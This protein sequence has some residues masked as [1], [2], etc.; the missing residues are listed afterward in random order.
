MSNW[1]SPS[2]LFSW[3]E[4]LF[5]KDKFP[6]KLSVTETLRLHVQYV[7]S[8]SRLAHERETSSL[9][10]LQLCLFFKVFICQLQDPAIT[11]WDHHHLHP[12][13]TWMALFQTHKHTHTGCH[14][15]GRVIWQVHTCSLHLKMEK[16][17]NRGMCESLFN[18][19]DI[20]QGSTC[21]TRLMCPYWAL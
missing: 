11:H 12:K 21:L 7:P 8:L 20:D 4:F 13:E 17:V 19:G 18:R 2:N 3:R 1:T 16:K 14:H 5:T 9:C 15:N 6:E 10:I